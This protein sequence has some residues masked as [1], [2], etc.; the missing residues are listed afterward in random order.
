[1]NTRMYVVTTVENTSEG[2]PD[3]T[4]RKEPAG[5]N[6][7]DKSRGKVPHE[8]REKEHLEN[9]RNGD[10]KEETPDARAIEQLEGAESVQTDKEENQAVEIPNED[11]EEIIESAE[12]EFTKKAEKIK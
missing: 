4:R 3:F 2:T 1:M 5:E 7:K 12:G 9:D 8:D 6:G 10:I 11:F